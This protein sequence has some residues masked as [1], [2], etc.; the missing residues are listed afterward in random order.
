MTLFF[1]NSVN[2]IIVYCVVHMIYYF[3]NLFI[4]FLQTKEC[5]IYICYLFTL[6]LTKEQSTIFEQ[7]IHD[8]KEQTQF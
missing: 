1:L 5:P 4:I 2:I 3:F 8:I 7:I 6:G